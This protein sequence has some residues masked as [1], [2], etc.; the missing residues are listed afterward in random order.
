MSIERRL[1]EKVT[2]VGSCNRIRGGSKNAH[3]AYLQ[4]LLTFK[5]APYPLDVRGRDLALKPLN[6]QR[7]NPRE[8]E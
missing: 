8:L 1:D 6:E 3:T 5:T 4:S 2:L 7:R